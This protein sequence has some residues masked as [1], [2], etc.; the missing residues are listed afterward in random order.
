MNATTTT[1]E[2]KQAEAD[3]LVRAAQ[4]Q[5]EALASFRRRHFATLEWRTLGEI[6]HATSLLGEAFGSLALVRAA[7]G[8]DA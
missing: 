3:A 8:G 2:L 5:L 7:A 4:R 1:P 6:D